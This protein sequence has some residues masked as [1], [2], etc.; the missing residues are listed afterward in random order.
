[1][2]VH[3]NFSYAR[4]SDGVLA[5][6]LQAATPIGGWTIQLT[7]TKRFG[8]PNI[9]GLI[10]KIAASGTGGGQS[11]ITITDS[12]QGRFNIRLDSGDTTN[13]DFG[14]YAGIIERTDSGFRT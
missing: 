7:V 14:N 9:S 10:N 3:A 5:V 13:L 8:S 1:M 2:P 11:G 6:G 12:G 4:Y